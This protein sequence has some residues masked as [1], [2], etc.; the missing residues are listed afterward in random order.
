MIQMND[1]LIKLT[2]SK[3][4]GLVIKYQLLTM[5]AQTDYNLYYFFFFFTQFLQVNSDLTN[6]TLT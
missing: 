4:V 1:H 6:Y 2:H 3:R 5:T